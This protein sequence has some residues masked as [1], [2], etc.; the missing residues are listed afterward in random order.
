MPMT[1]IERMN[2]VLARKPVDTTPVAVSPWGATV[3][4]WLLGFDEVGASVERFTGRRIPSE[5]VPAP[6][7]LEAFESI[8]ARAADPGN[9]AQL[10]RDGVW[11]RPG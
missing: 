4:R 8:A 5:R 11:R 1:S 9:V 2:N 3:E 6:V 7:A 10:E